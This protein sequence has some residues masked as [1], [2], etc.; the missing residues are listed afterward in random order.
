MVSI[1]QDTELKKIDHTQDATGSIHAAA[2][3]PQGAS[4]K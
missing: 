4:A 1:A 3:E 2:F